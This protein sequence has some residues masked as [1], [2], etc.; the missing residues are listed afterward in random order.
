MTE[1]ERGWKPNT[2]AQRSEL[3]YLAGFEF[4]G[5]WHQSDCEHCERRYSGPIRVRSCR[6]CSDIAKAY[7][8]GGAS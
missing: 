5:A 4:Q 7:A 8:A 3:D 6:S 2:V 1:E